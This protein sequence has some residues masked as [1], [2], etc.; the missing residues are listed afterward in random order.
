LDT[1][2]E[3]ISTVAAAVVIFCYC[4]FI[5]VIIII[6]IFFIKALGSKGSRGLK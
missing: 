4:Y 6:I 5:A 1:N 2:Y 3:I